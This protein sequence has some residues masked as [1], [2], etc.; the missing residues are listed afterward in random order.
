MPTELTILQARIRSLKEDA[1]RIERDADRRLRAVAAAIA[2]HG[3]TLDE[4]REAY[5]MSRTNTALAKY[6]DGK[7]NCWI[8]RGRPP[9]WLTAAEKAGTPRD[10]FLVAPIRT[11][12]AAQRAKAA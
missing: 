11:K 12:V 4:L 6:R 8:G 5:A 10:S 1:R 7:G 2:R 9:L 3:L